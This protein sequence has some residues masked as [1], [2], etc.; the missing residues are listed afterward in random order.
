MGGVGRGR[1][2]PITRPT[3]SYVAPF[4]TS[5]RVRKRNTLHKQ[6][7]CDHLAASLKDT[8]TPPRHLY[9]RAEGSPKKK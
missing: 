5:A 4:S 3:A 1:L 9:I 7:V 8:P 6:N 2:R